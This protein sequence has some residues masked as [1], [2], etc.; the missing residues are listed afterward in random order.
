MFCMGHLSSLLVVQNVLHNEHFFSLGRQNVLH[1]GSFF[2]LSKQNIL[3][4]EHFFSLDEQN[5]LTSSDQDTYHPAPRPAR[6]AS[7]FAC[8][9]GRGELREFFNLHYASVLTRWLK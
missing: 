1:N 7:L 9:A 3:R 8:R 6:R 4:N 2:S 5:A